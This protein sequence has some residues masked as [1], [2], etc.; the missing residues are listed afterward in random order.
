MNETMMFALVI[1]AAGFVATYIV[2]ILL[3]FFVALKSP[4][5]RR[6]IWTVGIAYLVISVPTVCLI[7]AADQDPTAPGRFPIDPWVSP[8]L[9]MP[10]AIVAFLLR[11]WEYRSAWVE[12]IEDLRDGEQLA[13]DDWRF[14]LIILALVIIIL[15][16]RTLVRRYLL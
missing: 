11:R 13:N 4:P 2:T 12:Q 7:L 16:G 3:N 15:T 10:G 6:A 14:G 8:L 9:L 1:A 5:N